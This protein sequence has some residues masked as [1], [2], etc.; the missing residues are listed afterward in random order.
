MFE[1]PRTFLVSG[2]QKAKKS[3]ILFCTT[4]DKHG[5]AMEPFI[6]LRESFT[7]LP[8]RVVEHDAF[9][10]LPGF[11]DST[12][13]EPNVNHMKEYRRKILWERKVKLQFSINFTNSTIFFRSVWRNLRPPHI[14]VC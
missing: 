5:R 2:R 11:V 9:N 4:F 13:L 7:F 14:L 1:C 10:Q 3:V 12:A 8:S 6:F